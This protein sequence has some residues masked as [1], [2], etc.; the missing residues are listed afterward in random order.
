MARPN[1]A[2]TQ[3]FGEIRAMLLHVF[4]Q[5]CCVNA[6]LSCAL[7]PLTFLVN[8]VSAMI[9]NGMGTLLA[10]ATDR[11]LPAKSVQFLYVK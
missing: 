3:H 10:A 2:F 6:A 9:P 4:S 5:K 8:N 11:F 7:A 1:A